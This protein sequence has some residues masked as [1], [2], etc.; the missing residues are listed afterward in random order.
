MCAN[1]TA[2]TSPFNLN[3]YFTHHIGNGAYSRTFRRR[4]GRRGATGREPELSF[5]RHERFNNT[6][7]LRFPQATLADLEDALWGP[8][9]AERAVEHAHDLDT[10]L[11]PVPKR[12]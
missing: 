1:Q 10:P 9:A 5:E 2:Y 4:G 6:L 7:E 12:S 11:K 3:K 8:S